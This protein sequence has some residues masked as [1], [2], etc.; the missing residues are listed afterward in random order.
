MRSLLTKRSC[1]CDCLYVWW[2]S[3]YDIIFAITESLAGAVTTKGGARKIR[4]HDVGGGGIDDHAFLVGECERW[5]AFLYF[6][7][8]CSQLIHGTRWG[9]TAKGMW[10]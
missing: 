2:V 8:C 6:G 7:S 10:F 5:I 3:I 1:G 4:S 9:T